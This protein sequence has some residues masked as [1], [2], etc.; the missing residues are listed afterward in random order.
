MEN[1]KIAITIAREFGSGGRIIGMKLAEELQIPCYDKALINMV[2]EKS[3]LDPKY[4]EK[5][6]EYVKS[7]FFFGLTTAAYIRSG[8][9]NEDY[10]VPVN[11]KVFFTQSEIIK[12]L[13]E[14]ESCI[15]VGRCS[16]Y[17]L[18]DEPNL[19]RIFIYANKEDKL[20]RA[21][22]SYN[23][24]EAEAKEK[25]DTVDKQRSNYYACHTY[26]K[27]G[28]IKEYDIMINSSCTDIDGAVKMIAEIARFK[29]QKS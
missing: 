20:K 19:I 1:K 2:A 16:N 11:F 7:K 22:D 12:N 28:D 4:V 5:T 3:G 21:I 13:A 9:F 27:W 18:K 24:S 14:K 6:E 17:I 10:N 15:I 25:L 29:M 26:N 8:V 23:L